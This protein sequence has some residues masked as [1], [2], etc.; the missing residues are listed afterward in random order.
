MKKFLDLSFWFDQ[1]P[2]ALIPLWR[3]VLIAILISCVILAA[4]T[5]ILKGRKNIYRQLFEKLFYFFNINFIIGL[6]L[7]FFNQEIVPVFSSRFWYI[8]W[9][10]ILA[11]WIYSIIRYMLKLPAKKE[12]FKK[13][14][15]FEKYLPK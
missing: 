1:Q 11:I 3:N 15:E 10:I 4:I 7:F 6:V 12:D 9:A 5:F 8:I 13:Q 2:G 14:R